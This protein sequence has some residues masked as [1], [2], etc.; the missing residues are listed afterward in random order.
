ML[1]IYG[2]R[3][4]LQFSIH[5]ETQVYTF[6]WLF[7]VVAAFWSS[8]MDL[9]KGVRLMFLSEIST[10]KSFVYVCYSRIQFIMFV[11]ATKPQ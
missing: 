2:K 5:T 11:F 7:T 3:D 9:N 6:L 10:F 4:L 8:S 1:L